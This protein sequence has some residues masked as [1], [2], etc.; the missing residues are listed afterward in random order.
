MCE[1][2]TS[3]S[4]RIE[5]QGYHPQ[6]TFPAPPGQRLGRNVDRRNNMVIDLDGSRKNGTYFTSQMQLIQGRLQKFCWKGFHATVK[7]YH[8]D[9]FIDS[10]LATEPACR[11]PSATRLRRHRLQ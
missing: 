7:S 5:Y 3:L 9:R 10:P 2:L 4:S 1:I 11:D 8:A 6:G